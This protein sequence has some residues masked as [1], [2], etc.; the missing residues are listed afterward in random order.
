MQSIITTALC[1]IPLWLSAQS[2]N[3]ILILADDMGWNGTSVQL[4]PNIPNSASDFYET[5]NI[6]QLANDGMTFS[7]GYAPAPKCSPTR[8]AILTGESPAR[9]SFTETGNSISSGEILIEPNTN[10]SIESSDVTLAEWLKSIGQNYRT[11]HFGKWHLGSN[12]PGDHG[13]DFSDGAT[14]NNDGNSANGNTI[15]ED[16]KK[17]FDLTDRSIL[18]M[19]DAVEDEV[20]FFLQLS[21]YAVHGGVETTQESFDFFDAKPPGAIHDNVDFAGMTKDL[22]EGIG[23]LLQ[24]IEDLDIAN[25]TYVIFLSDNGSG[26]LSDNTPLRE[27]K[28]YIFEGGI[29][30]PFIIKGPNIPANT[31]SSTPINGYDLFPTIAEWTGS[32]TALPSTLDG[33]SL[34][35][36]LNQNTFTRSEALYFHL[37]HYSGNVNK[38]PRSAAVEGK[39]KL[40]VEYQTGI[41]YLY[42]LEADIGETNNLAS[43]YPTILNDLKIKLRN[44]LKAVDANMPSLDPNHS[45]FSGAGTDVDNDGLDDE[46]EL[47]ELLSYTYTA[48]DDP[49]NDGDDNLTE[50]INDTDPLT[51]GNIVI[52]GDGGFENGWGIWNDGG[53]DCRR[54]IND[55]PF[56]NSGSFCVRLRD[57]DPV[58]SFMTTDVLDLT[59]Y[60]ELTVD[61]SYIVQSFENTEDFWLQLSTDGGLTFTTIEDWVYT[62]DFLN[63]ERHNPS[64]VINSPFTSTTVLR[65][66]CDASRNNDFVYFDDVVI[67]GLLSS[68]FHANTERIIV[69]EE[70][71]NSSGLEP[72]SY[73]LSL[74]N[75][76][77]AISD[78]RLF[79]NPANDNLN[80]DFT[81]NRATEV[82]MSVTDFS[83]RLLIKQ[84]FEREAG[85]HTINQN[86]GELP[87]GSY[88]VQ[89]ITN[90]GKLSEKF[91][92]IK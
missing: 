29:R 63:A 58:S 6:Q 15:Q 38:Q 26:G 45:S 2:P 64:V 65:F 16:P 1:L 10:N 12:G 52:I 49:D 84:E 81:L 32:S 87:A 78:L 31:T 50:F 66:R 7:Q 37:P 11:G 42:D 33:E 69:N 48:S 23:L 89:L 46:W 68:N 4:S 39:Y 83:G 59:A 79:P 76:I 92:V 75:D 30:V 18:F 77:N 85:F 57:D 44:H 67:T 74:Q 14:A 35:P 54:N 22:D 34:V 41:D 9:N 82:I 73:D 61:F 60:D 28:A 90:Q 21:H 24:E 51:G 88:F 25:D 72:I 3:I 17:I 80:L 13:F 40:L 36:L 53:S 5:P 8:C 56:A 62:I 70:N 55:A 91:V 19:Q 47:R 20:P 71:P 86:V 27:G 43:T